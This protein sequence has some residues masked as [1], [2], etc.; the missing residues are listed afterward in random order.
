MI[1]RKLNQTADAIHAYQRALKLNPNYAQ[2]FNNLASI[3]HSQGRVGEA[4]D[5]LRKCLQLSPSAAF[6]SN[7]LYTMW[8]D[9]DTSPEQIAAEHARWAQRW[10]E[11]LAGEIRPCKNDPDPNRRLRIGY[12]SPDFKEHVIA[13]FMQPILHHRDRGGFEVFCYADVAAPDFM[14][15]PPKSRCR[16]LGAH[17]RNVLRCAG[18]THSQRSNRYCSGLDCSHDR[19]S[20]ARICPQSCADT[21]ELPCLRRHNRIANNGLSPQ[22]SASGPRRRGNLR[23]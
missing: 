20:D 17:H 4:A 16:R 10:T 19:K 22:R 7:L 21:V 14:T 13:L 3:S 18:R 1:L 12:V 11:P 5:Y 9:P 23:H 8:F 2:A 15:Q 6:H